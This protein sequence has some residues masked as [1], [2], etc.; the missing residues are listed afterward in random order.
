MQQPPSAA[1]SPGL[2]DHRQDS[3]LPSPLP[4]S[5]PNM[6]P[7]SPHITVEQVV[8]APARPALAPHLSAPPTAP[9]FDSPIRHHR[10]TPSQHREIKETLNARTE[11]KN[12]GEDG[13]SQHTINQYVI[14][15]EIG[16]GSYG[17]VHLATDQFGNEYALKEFSKMRL[18]KRIQSHILR[19][20][21][22]S[23]PQQLGPGLGRWASHKHKLSLQEDAEA[24]DA[25]YLIR[26]E[27]AI[28]KKL[29]HPNLVSLIEVL[30]DPEEDSLYMV[31]EM[32]KKGVVMKVTLEEQADPYDDQRC[33]T[34]FRDLILGIE[35]LH[36]Q[37]IVHRDI[38]PDNLLLT[39]DDVLKIVDFGVSEM[40]E[41][42]DQMLTSK[43]AGSPAFLAPELC[44]AKHGS[45]LGTAA[46][47]WS[48]GVTLYCLKYGKLPF[49]GSNVLDMY[50]A[51][52]TEEL[53]IPDG[54]DPDFVDLITRILDKD[55]ERRITL[56]EV[57]NHPWITRAG[58]DPL[59][60]EEENC[61]DMIEPPNEL[62]VNHAFT[63]KMDHLLCVL[64]AIH[65][66]KG[67]TSTS[68]P[69]TPQALRA[70]RRAVQ[71]AILG[72]SEAPRVA[73]AEELLSPT[74]QKSV[75]EEAADLVEQ[76]QA[77]LASVKQG[78]SQF[79]PVPAAGDDA[80]GG[81]KG[82]AQDLTEKQP[83]FLGIGTGGRDDFSE[84]ETPADVVSDSPTGIDYDIYD[85]A[86]G[87]EI[88]RIRSDKKKGRARTYLTRL[89][90]EE[91]MQ[92]YADDD[93]MVVEAG[94]SLAS[95]AYTRGSA[96]ASKGL[97][98]VSEVGGASHTEGQQLKEYLELKRH[99][100]QDS[101][102]KVLGGARD[103]G[104]KF[105]DLVTSLT[106][107]DKAP[108]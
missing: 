75:A 88:K 3:L 106:K 24:K 28:M 85:H 100:R 16:R 63:R 4:N 37:G 51:I 58:T 34:W 33:W 97:E 47:V 32:C 73:K 23:K 82:H 62:E 55:H 90:G 30:D 95:N 84:A 99:E 92:K 94:K 79:A 38:K 64:R 35:Y 60:P 13:R 87:T 20:P 93:C 14:K 41:K 66:F 11:Y 104:H 42:H 7:S 18:R 44:Q 80:A 81:D 89:V 45:V 8:E 102:K 43:S 59:L 61:S 36:A 101:V 83:L 25:L 15:E 98:H 6:S 86:F 65:K 91:E 52:R 12:E 1:S 103:A 67:L 19:R 107:K 21:A 76:R 22:G 68:Q 69:G 46:D 105:A 77:Y 27:I 74:R 54:E 96:F 48:M 9:H 29:D 56:H 10:R 70:P 31:L 57:R 71:E 26:E 78:A 50:N 5:H 49:Q 2:P 17:A 108:E 40:F 72:L 39:E 53:R